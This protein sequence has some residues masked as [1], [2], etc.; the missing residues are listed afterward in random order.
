MILLYTSPVNSIK[1]GVSRN[2]VGILENVPDFTVL[3]TFLCQRKVQYTLSLRLLH[4]LLIMFNFQN[5][6]R[7]MIEGIVLFH[8]SL[9]TILISISTRIMMTMFIYTYGTTT[10]RA[11][12]ESQTVE[13]LWT[14]TPVFILLVLV[15]PSLRLLYLTED[16]VIV[17]SITKAIGHQWY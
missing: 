14:I 13:F 1:N 3:E 12:T 4:E 9:L 17:Q 6:S 11:F 7:P 16:N 2:K 8:D 10:Y 5:P 15:A